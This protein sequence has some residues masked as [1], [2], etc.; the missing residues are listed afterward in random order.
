MMRNSDDGSELSAGS[1]VILATAGALTEAAARYATNELSAA[2]SVDPKDPVGGESSN[3]SLP[4]R[5]FSA[6]AEA[7]ASVSPRMLIST[8][9]WLGSTT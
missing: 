5:G 7:T 3:Y 6:R 9:I 8:R 1:N 2:E 4:L